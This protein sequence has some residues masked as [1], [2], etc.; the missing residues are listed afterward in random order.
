MTLKFKP[1]QFPQDE[2]AHGNIIE[3]WYFNGH[4]KDKSGHRYSFMD[5]FFKTDVIRQL[6]I[7]WRGLRRFNSLTKIEPFDIIIL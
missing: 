1:I 6:K 2:H 5:C 3:W 4:L 7:C